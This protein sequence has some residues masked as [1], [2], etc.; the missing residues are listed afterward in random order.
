[1]N[2]DWMNFEIGAD[3]NVEEIMQK[4][5]AAIAEKQKAGIYTEESIEELADS[6]IMQFAEEA[7]IDSA[8]LERLRSPDHSWNISPSYLITSHRT[9]IKAGLIKLTKRMVRPF[10]RLY[11]D[12]IFGRQAQ[13]NLY[14]AHLLHNL[15]RELTRLQINHTSLKHRTDRLEREKEFFEQRIRTLEKMV[16]FQSD[17][18]S[19]DS[20]VQ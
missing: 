8:L 10:V 12:H 16:K 9:G 17:G 15:V 13:I 19:A 4:I 14:F 1:M 11:T 5:R 20:N 18:E 2:K 7:E 3:I 6:K